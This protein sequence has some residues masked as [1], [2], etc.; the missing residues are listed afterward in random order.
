MDTFSVTEVEAITII[1]MSSNFAITQIVDGNWGVHA[2]VPKW[3]FEK[4]GK[5]YDYSLDEP[6]NGRTPNTIG[7]GLASGYGGGRRL[8]GHHAVEAVAEPQ[9]DPLGWDRMGDDLL[10][11]V[12]GRSAKRSAD[13]NRRR[14]LS[15][16][17]VAAMPMELAES[18][19]A[20]KFSAL[21]REARAYVDETFALYGHLAHRH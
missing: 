18:L 17:E 5:G 1:S 7:G 20:H 10:S 2:S 4:S 9:V 16:E 3:V 14:L 8:H 6:I 15:R 21:K 11:F 19:L 12:T 13:A